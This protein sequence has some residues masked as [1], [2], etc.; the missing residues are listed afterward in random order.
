MAGARTLPANSVSPE[1]FFSRFPSGV[2]RTAEEL[3]GLIRESI[4][5][6]VERVYTGWKLVGYRVPD[7]KKSWYCCYLYPRE[8]SVELGFEHGTLLSDPSR[9]LGGDGAQVR[10][11]VFRAASPL[12][13]KVIRQLLREAALITL[14]GKRWKK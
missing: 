12:D 5:G 6:V 1:T 8:D 11:I 9:V 10:K 4:P 7:G 2:A 14:E 13:T 3:R